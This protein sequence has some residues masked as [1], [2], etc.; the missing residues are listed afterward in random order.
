MYQQLYN[1]ELII[2][3]FKRTTSCSTKLNLMVYLLHVVCSYQ[4]QACCLL[5][6]PD[7]VCACCLLSISVC[8]IKEHQGKHLSHFNITLI[9]KAFHKVSELDLFQEKCKYQKKI[10]SMIIKIEQYVS[11]CMLFNQEM[12]HIEIA[13]WHEETVRYIS[14]KNIICST[15]SL[16]GQKR[17]LMSFKI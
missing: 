7:T 15:L 9:N 1:N 14:L 16:D 2:F 13:I 4:P 3:E 8:Q 6:H 11:Y 5:F 10:L 17:F 12:H